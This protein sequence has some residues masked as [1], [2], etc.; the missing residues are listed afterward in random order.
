MAPS[1]TKDLPVVAWGDESC[2][3]SENGLSYSMIAVVFDAWSDD[4]AVALR[5]IMPKGALKLHWYEIVPDVKAKSIAAIESMGFSATIVRAVP[6]AAAK[7]ERTRHKCLTNILPILE[8]K[9][10]SAFVLKSRGA[11]LDKRDVKLLDGLKGS[12]MVSSIR[13]EHVRGQDEPRLWV[14]D[15]ILGAFGDS[16][17]VLGDN[18]WESLAEQVSV[19]T[20]VP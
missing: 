16:C 8:S 19:T 4:D 9:G 5:K 13:L 6:A 1:S 20:L 10:V 15:Q 3:G 11:A 7:Q 14:A 18:Y 2:R 12:K 17:A